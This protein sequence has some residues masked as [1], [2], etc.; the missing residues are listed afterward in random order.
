MTRHLRSLIFLCIPV[1]VGAPDVSRAELVRFE[2]VEVESHPMDVISVIRE[3][4][5]LLQST[6]PPN[7]VFEQYLDANCG[8]IV[9]NQTVVHQLLMNLCT[10]AAQAMEPNGGTVTILAGTAQQTALPAELDPLAA[11]GW[12]RIGIADTGMAYQRKFAI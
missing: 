4:A 1:T 2:I 9:A 10:N 8:T 5:D 3:V 11:D 7:T 6:L 12:L